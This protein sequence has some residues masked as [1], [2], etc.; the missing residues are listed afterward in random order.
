MV[1]LFAW[2]WVATALPPELLGGLYK[3]RYDLANDLVA[4]GPGGRLLDD[5]VARTVLDANRLPVVVGPHWIICAQAHAH[6]GARAPVGCNTPQRDDF[7][8]WYPRSRWLQAPVVLF[9]HDSRFPVDAEHELPGRIVKSV[10]KVD[11]RRGGRV[12]RTIWVTRLDKSEDVGQLGAGAWGRSPA[13]FT[14]SSS[15]EGSGLGV[16][17]SVSP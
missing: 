7:D 17:S 11:V 1:T 9:V 6:L 15:A 10:S 4:W 16:V 8:R 13:A 2:L 3:P 5:A 12:V 14:K